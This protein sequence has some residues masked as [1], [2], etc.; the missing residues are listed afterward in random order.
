MAVPLMWKEDNCLHFTHTL[1]TPEC[2]QIRAPYHSLAQLQKSDKPHCL[3]SL[4]TNWRNPIFFYH[5]N[6]DLKDFTLTLGLNLSSV[7][8]SGFPLHGNCYALSMCSETE[9]HSCL[10]HLRCKGN[11]TSTLSFHRGWL[12][13]WLQGC[14]LQLQAAIVLSML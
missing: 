2:L 10:F 12:G 5:L 14:L 9:K 3:L 1:T 4:L 13:F 7:K 6:F 8:S 11:V